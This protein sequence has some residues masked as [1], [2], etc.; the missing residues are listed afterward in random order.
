MLLTQVMN[1]ETRD[2]LSPLID[3]LVQTA[4]RQ[5]ALLEQEAPEASFDDLVAWTE[6]EALIFDDPG[7]ARLSVMLAEAL[8]AMSEHVHAPADRVLSLSG[9]LTRDKAELYIKMAGS[10]RKAEQLTGIARS[11]LWRAIH[12]EVAA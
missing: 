2:G 6:E 8:T 12:Q 9:F 7:Q 4:S 11:T 10:L 1:T 3:F 5:P